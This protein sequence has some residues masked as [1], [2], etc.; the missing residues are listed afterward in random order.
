MQSA[1]VAEAG[2]YEVKIGASSRDIRQNAFFNLNDDITVQEVNN[3]LKPNVTARPVFTALPSF[4][5]F[6]G[7]T[8]N[9]TVQ[10]SN[11]NSSRLTYTSPNLPAGAKLDQDS[12]EFSW[13]PDDGQSGTYTVQVRCSNQLVTVETTV[14]ILVKIPI[15]SIKISAPAMVSV[16][17]GGNYTFEV[18]LNEGA[19]DKDIIWTVSNPAYAVIEDDGSVQILNK[20]GNVILIATDPYSKLNYSIVLRIT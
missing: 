10:A 19:L 9:F 17:R 12:G 2:S 1:F 6:E 4:E 13:T 18:I 20:T 15:T 11:P 16:T 8:L 7:Q 3:V 14:D 5:V